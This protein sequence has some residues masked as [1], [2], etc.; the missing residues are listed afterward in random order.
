MRMSLTGHCSAML[1]AYLLKFE[2][3]FICNYVMLI[4]QKILFLGIKNYFI[5]GCNLFFESLGE[6]WCLYYICNT[7]TISYVNHQNFRRNR[8]RAGSIL[9]R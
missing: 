7:N 9:F 8:E 3:F 1:S 2:G 4:D 5:A 6:K